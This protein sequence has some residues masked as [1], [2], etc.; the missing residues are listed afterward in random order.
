MQTVINFV[1]Q[2]KKLTVN[3]RLNIT[4]KTLQSDSL[5]QLNIMSTKNDHRLSLQTVNI[6]LQDWTKNTH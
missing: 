3:F 5:P 4:K 2:L 6:C 1:K